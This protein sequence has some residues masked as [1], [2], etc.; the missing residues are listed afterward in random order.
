MTTLEALSVCTP[1]L[2]LPSSQSVLALT[3]GMIRFMELPVDLTALLLPNNVSDYVKNSVAILQGKETGYLQ[4]IRKLIC[5]NV[6]D[7]YEQQN[8]S[9]E[10]NLLFKNLGNSIRKT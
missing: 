8:S 4:Q 7:L 9:E 5:E 3:A 10:W 1:V 6:G 2:S